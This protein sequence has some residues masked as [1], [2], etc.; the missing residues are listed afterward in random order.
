M[1]MEAKHTPGPWKATPS[2]PAEGVECIWIT[3]CPEPNQEKEI[4]A[5]Y[6]P[7]NERNKATA[8]LIAVAPVLLEALKAAHKRLRNGTEM[9]QAFAAEFIAPALATLT[10]T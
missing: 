4:A 10:R 7:Q 9:D 1:K 3:A 8:A 5:V 6:G 2:D